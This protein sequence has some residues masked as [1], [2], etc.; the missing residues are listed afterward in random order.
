VR[1]WKLKTLRIG[2]TIVVLIGLAEAAVRYRAYR[3]TGAA[4]VAD[5]DLYMD[6]KTFGQVL[7]P[8][9]QRRTAEGVMTINSL[10]FRG[11]EFDPAKA[12]GS[13]RIAFLGDSVIFGGQLPRDDQLFTI[14]LE[15]KLA[16][17]IGR[18][19]SVINAAVPGYTLDVTIK[20]YT[21]RVRPLQPD[22][23]VICQEVND[24]KLALRQAFASA[25]T[26]QVQQAD[27]SFDPAREL[28]KF[29]D[30]HF[31]IYHL[32]R[33][34]LTPLVTPLGEGTDAHDTLPP[35]V[36][37]VYRRQ[38]TELVRRVR[39]DG[40][41]VVLC[42]AWK[43]F[44]KDQPL[45]EQ[46]ANAAGA[47]LILPNVSLEGLYA[48]FDLFNNTVRQVAAE[49]GAVLI[50]TA[51]LIPSDPNIFR[52]PTHLNAAGHKLLAEVLTERLAPLLP[53]GSGGI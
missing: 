45:A 12:P 28:A 20:V 48:A 50:D 35:D 30:E 31:L 27:G 4:G 40:V 33:K 21:L 8:G 11:R 49:Q 14:Q 44:S 47:L 46:R 17:Q 1:P 15:E 19:L 22:M 24:L 7:R 23:V 39:G 52:D 43:A 18:P 37:D 9:L 42:T 34:N 6:D 53:E 13:Y 51:R 3:R 2:L 29:R 36:A 5:E 25:E 16:R 32:I 41:T 26:E 38:L 10:G